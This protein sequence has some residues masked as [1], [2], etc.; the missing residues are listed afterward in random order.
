MCDHIDIEP[1]DI[2]HR[3]GAA[4]GMSQTAGLILYL[5]DVVHSVSFSKRLLDGLGIKIEKVHTLEDVLR[6]VLELDDG[7][8]T[9]LFDYL[10]ERNEETVGGQGH[11][12]LSPLV[13]LT[14]QH[15]SK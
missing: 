5:G 13:K 10:P 14:L 2:E 4:E 1:I 3:V 12:K 7:R 11:D 15:L 6:L 8:V 9:C